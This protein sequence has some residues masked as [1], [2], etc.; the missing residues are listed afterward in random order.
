MTL[1]PFFGEYVIAGSKRAAMEADFSDAMLSPDGTKEILVADF[2]DF[3]MGSDH[4]VYEE[5]SFRIPTIYLN[6]WPDVFIHTNNDLP[7]NLDSTKLQRVAVIGAA[8]GYF[9]ATAGAAQA[10]TLAGEVFARGQARA[11]ESLL[12]ASALASNCSP[13]KPC[14][15]L[16]EA[17][18]LVHQAAEQERQTLLSIEQLASNQSSLQTLL[19]QMQKRV[20]P[21]ENDAM[22]IL[23]DNHTGLNNPTGSDEGTGLNKMIPKRN[24]AVVGNLNVYYYDYLRDHF[25]NE[26]FE[27]LTKL[28]ALPQ[29]ETI[30]YETL[31]LIDGRRSG[32][33]IKNILDA[34]YG[35][36]P[37][38]ILVSYLKLLE[39]MRVISIAQ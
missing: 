21:N 1:L 23:Q 18:N 35:T 5:G 31:N 39:K 16:P 32:I 4:D 24:P 29:G 11:A 13:D 37:E 12:R 34:A 27:V 38:D 17:V 9:L 25:P 20:D 33:E 19:Q 15:Q 26:N 6:D 14:S 8:S 22:T 3:T 10:V 36:V 2:H 28:E 30:A 7:S